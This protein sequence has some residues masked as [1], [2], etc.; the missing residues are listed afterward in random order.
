MWVFNMLTLH[1]FEHVGNHCVVWRVAYI[2]LWN[3]GKTSHV[4]DLLMVS[5]KVNKRL[6]SCWH[7]CYWSFR[8]SPSKILPQSNSIVKPTLV[9]MTYY[10]HVR[11]SKCYT[12]IWWLWYSEKIN[13]HTTNN[14]VLRHLQRSVR[15]NCQTHNGHFQR[16]ERSQWK[17]NS[18]VGYMLERR[19]KSGFQ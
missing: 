18:D 14:K 8:K 10:E 11:K 7:F 5:E 19:D 12:N 4:L 3:Y 16:I 2:F 1:S 6:P 9:W 15:S 17:T 13:K